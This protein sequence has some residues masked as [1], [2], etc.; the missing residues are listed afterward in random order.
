VEAGVRA[1]EIAAVDLVPRE[2]RGEQAAAER[3]VGHLA[4]AEPAGG[5]DDVVLGLAPEQRPLELH[6]G[7]RVDGV[8]GLELV[9]GDLG[10]AEVPHLALMDELCHRAD[11]LGDRG[12]GVHAVQVVEVDGL[13]E[14]T[15]DELFGP[16]L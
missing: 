15:F 3:A 12:L 14:R 13:D 6:R 5:R 9:A 1:A 2:R 4:H 16:P 10:D 8:R 7:D 11:G